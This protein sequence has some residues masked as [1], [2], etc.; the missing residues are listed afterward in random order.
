[1]PTVAI[2]TTDANEKAQAIHSRMPVTLPD[3]EAAA[4]WI[5]P[6]ADRAALEELLHPAPGDAIETYPVSRR[7]NKPE[8]DDAGCIE[9]A[10]S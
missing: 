10:S 7:V 5:E 3:D 8:H 1:V 4:A 6:D 2:L 9:A